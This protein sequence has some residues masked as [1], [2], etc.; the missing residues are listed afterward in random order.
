MAGWARWWGWSWML[1]PRRP[2]LLELRW[3]EDRHQP[4]SAQGRV[5]LAG[6]GRGH[7][8]G[9]FLMLR[10]LR[11]RVVGYATLWSTMTTARFRKRGP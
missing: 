3:D 10:G 9:L 11:Y 1:H 7:E 2:L 5:A 6:S 8:E 4:S